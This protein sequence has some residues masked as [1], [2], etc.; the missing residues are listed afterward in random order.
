MDL[1]GTLLVVNNA[2]ADLS[3]LSREEMLGKP[4]WEGPWWR[5]DSAARSQVREAILRVARDGEPMQFE[6]T[7]VDRDEQIHDIQFNLRALRD[8]TGRIA[9]LIAE[10]LDITDLKRS[11]QALQDGREWYRS[12]FEAAN[13]A[14]F[15]MEEDRFVDCNP[16]TLAL[17]GGTREQILQ[18]HPYDLSPEFQPD[19]RPSA[20]KALEKIS[21]AYGGESQSFEWRHCRIDGSLFDVAVTLNRVFL[22]GQPHL[23]AVVRDITERKR[24]EEALRN[25]MAFNQTLISAS[26]AFFVAIGA[27]GKTRMMNPAMLNALGYTAQEVVGKDYMS[28]FVPDA[29]RGTLARVF[30]QLVAGRPTLNENHIVSKDGRLLLVEWHGAP[31]FKGQELDYFFGVGI[32][33]TERRRAE[34]EI[35][36]LNAELEQRVRDR[37]AQLAAANAALN[38]FAY[39]VS[40]DLK[41]PLRAVSQ[42]AQWVSEDYASVLDEE[43]KNRLKLMNGRIARMHSLID[44]ILQY[45]RIGRVEEDRRPIDLDLLVHE[46]IETLAP[47]PHVCVTV[48]GRLPVVVADRTQME[49]V[50][51]NLIGNAI[52]FMDKPA[53]LVTVACEDAGDRWRFSVTDNGPGI[54]PKYHEK[55]FGIFQTLTP[56]DQQESTGIGLTLVRRIVELYNGKVELESE[57]GKGSTFTFTLPK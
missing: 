20:Q 24:A 1:Q 47:P 48:E 7:H 38:E 19:G 21:A 49:Q 4:F 26:P 43:G 44:G 17:F 10:G 34:E 22:A 32:D 12:L 56:R 6:T 37:T 25:E 40:H 13:D 18:L 9:L 55:I 45:S 42:L 29:D 30:E 28:T 50:F 31:V 53:G 3:G 27:D 51:Q 14:I 16:R 33:I 23:V 57:V 35:R 2:A 5:H 36:K 39:V 15:L 46:L 11:Q 8:D 41:A 52:K 54:H